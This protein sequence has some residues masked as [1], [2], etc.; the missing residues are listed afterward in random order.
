MRPDKEEDKERQRT[1]IRKQ[2]NELL[3]PEESCPKKRGTEA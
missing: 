2:D 1:R 3:R